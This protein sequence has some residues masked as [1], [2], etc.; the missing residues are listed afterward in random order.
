ML[1]ALKKGPASRYPTV[2]AFAEDIERHI[3]NR[4]VLARPDRPWYRFSN[5]VRRNRIG[6]AAAG[7]V[8]I[9]LL[10]G[11]AMVAWQAQVAFAQRR[12][13]EQ[14]KTFS[15]Q[16]SWTPTPTEELE[17]LS[18]HW[19]SSNRRSSGSTEMQ[20]AGPETR[21]ELLNILGACLLS[22]QDTA[23][24]EAAVSR[25]VLESAV[26]SSG[27]PQALRAR[28]LMNWIHLFRGDPDGAA[29]NRRASG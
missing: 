4:P 19:I 26:L 18:P 12:R 23:G 13:A 27:H 9:T 11:S 1:K 7:A 25:S 20:G 14:V 6:V 24:A 28:M 15:S 29:R 17:S 2:D 8:V 3:Q 16:F 5:F 22:Q 10:A 21:V